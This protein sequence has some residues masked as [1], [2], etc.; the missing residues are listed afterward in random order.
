MN[1]VGLVVVTTPAIRPRKGEPDVLQVG[2]KQVAS[3]APTMG[4]IPLAKFR[5][6]LKP[7]PN[8]CVPVKSAG[9]A[10]VTR[11]RRFNG[12]LRSGLRNI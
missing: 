2:V 1:G 7:N 3:L 10:A 8:E 12:V 4:T 5:G 11:T 9:A 6:A